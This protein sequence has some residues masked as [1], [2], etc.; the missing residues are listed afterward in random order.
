MRRRRWTIALS[1]GAI[2]WL[3]AGFARAGT[4]T[5]EGAFLFDPQAA[6]TLDF[7]EPA[8]GAP[9]PVEDAGALHGTKVL[10][11]G[12][13]EGGDIEV[14]LPKELRS[15]RA[16]AWIRGAEAVATVEVS[17]SDRVDDVAVLYPTGRVTSDGWVEVQNEGIRIDGPR[18]TKVTLGA[19]APYGAALD[20]FELVPDGGAEVFPPTP[21]ASCGGIADTSACA[22]DQ[23]CVFNECRNAGG[24][25]PKIPDD[26]DR[27][28]AYL[29]SR[30]TLL[31]GPFYE[32]A[33]HLPSSLLAIEQMK[34]ASGPWSFWNSFALSIRRLHD[35]H[36][37]TG[38]VSDSVL[39]NRRSLGVCFIEGDADLTHV[40]APKDPEHLDVLVSHVKTGNVL[41]MRAGD[42]LL[43]VDGKHPIAWARSLIESHWSLPPVSNPRTFAELSSS[44]HRLIGRYAGSIEVIRCDAAQGTCGSPETISIADI[45]FNAPGMPSGNVTCDNRPLRHLPDAPEDHGNDAPS[46]VYSGIVVESDEAEGIYGLEWESMYTTTGTDGVGAGLKSAVSTWK[47]APAKGVI[48]DHRTGTGGTIL[49]PRIL[50]GYSVPR[51]ASDYYEDRQRFEDELPAQAEA[52][53]VFDAA[54]MEGTVSYAGTQNPVK[55]VPVA[56]LITEDVSASDWFALG[57]KG[58]P[59]V[60]LFGP[61]ETNGAFSTRYAFGYWLGMSVVLAV[62][63]TFLPEG[64]T[65][66]GTGVAPDEIVMPLQSDLVAGKDTVFEAALAWVRSEKLP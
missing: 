21:N 32:R 10:V 1:L 65:A 63:D 39:R 43:K 57:M 19:F 35:G 24:W 44:L 55:D 5:P 64:G 13:F 36:T 6:V 59:K 29:E 42:R 52:Q 47:T 54:V 51:H 34:A 16:T 8:E 37:S 33:F 38:N 49:A 15:Y 14:T 3:G 18:A 61:Y 23:L 30:L 48:L 22:A 62:G 25:V 9:P 7:E 56:V 20:A 46:G 17:Y 50:W 58:A 2:S 27:V 41:G 28:T 11:L 26:R 40:T 12:A 53:A 31:F 66:N 4:F 45:P 60:K